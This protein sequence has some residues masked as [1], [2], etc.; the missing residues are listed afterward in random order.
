LYSTVKNGNSTYTIKYYLGAGNQVV[1]KNDWLESQKEFDA[2]RRNGPKYN[3]K[4]IQAIRGWFGSLSK[5]L[6]VKKFKIAHVSDNVFNF[7]FTCSVKEQTELVET[8]TTN[9][10]RVKTPLVPQNGQQY[11]V[12]VIP[13]ANIPRVFAREYMVAF[14]IGFKRHDFANHNNSMKNN[15]PTPEELNLYVDKH[16]Q[17]IKDMTV[18]LFMQNMPV[19]YVGGV[20]RLFKLNLKTN[21]SPEEVAQK[22]KTLEPRGD[23]YYPTKNGKGELGYLK[24]TTVAING[25]LY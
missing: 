3:T 21:L 17:S 12:K 24:V 11:N 19:V 15:D 14:G 22:L 1:L 25:K 20:G 18:E 2:V 13:V 16:Q 10:F 5:E 4:D 6:P 7:S 8:L 23:L 9:M